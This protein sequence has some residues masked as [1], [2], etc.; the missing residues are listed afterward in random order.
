[1]VYSIMNIVWKNNQADD[2]NES[3]QGIVTCDLNLQEAFKLW[4]SW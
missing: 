3:Y 2:L 1:M 4:S